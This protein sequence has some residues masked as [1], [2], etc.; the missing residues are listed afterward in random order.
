MNNGGKT[1]Q[2]RFETNDLTKEGKIISSI[3][4][5]YPLSKENEVNLEK[6]FVDFNLGQIVPNKFLPIGSDPADNL[7]CLSIESE[8]K[9]SVYHCDLDYLEE[10]GELKT[11]YIRLISRNFKE[12]INS[13]YIPSQMK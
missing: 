1:K 2:R 9:N 11:E 5:F 7:I 4:L 8:D 12:F 3:K 6:M 13:L 10:D